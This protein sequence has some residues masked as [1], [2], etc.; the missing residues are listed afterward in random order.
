MTTI[1][2][3]AFAM[4][5]FAPLELAEKWDNVGLLVG[6]YDGKVR[7]VM[8]ALDMDSKTALEAIEKK[9]DLVITHHPIM[10]EP[11]NRITDM[12]AQ[13]RIIMQLI[14]HDVAMY[15]AHTNLDSA[16]GGVNDILAKKLGLSGVEKLETEGF[17]GSARVGFLQKP[18]P[19]GGFCALV[20]QRL[21]STLIKCV[22][23]KDKQVIK[24]ALCGGSGA[25]M[26]QAAFE[27]SCDVL[28]T[29]EAKYHD[30]QAA[31][32][33]GIALVEAGHYE[34]EAAVCEAIKEYLQSKFKD[35]EIFISDR[36]TTYYE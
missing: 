17:D 34:T 7:R 19:L 36:N 18:M 11:V 22:G 8:I 14:K 27:N 32:E 33:L 4:E 31:Y 16:D 26:L 3:M 23:E 25:F 15:A 24:V 13:G 21:N 12:T 35:V 6:Q 2:D 9:A 5:S 30:E 29:G 28:L 10:L 1:R 20:K